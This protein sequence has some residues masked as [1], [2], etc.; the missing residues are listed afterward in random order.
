MFPDVSCG[1]YLF[2]RFWRSSDCGIPGANYPS[3]GS[4][5]N[6]TNRKGLGNLWHSLPRGLSPSAS[7]GSNFFRWLLWLPDGRF[8]ERKHSKRATGSD[9]DHTSTIRWVRIGAPNC[10][11]SGTGCRER[12]WRKPR[13][14]CRTVMPSNTD[15]LTI[16]KLPQLDLQTAQLALQDRYRERPGTFQCSRTI[17]AYG[18]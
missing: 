16:V 1:R 8:P 18:A 12:T 6:R 10:T 11:L 15:D 17:S 9:G 4:D 13:L 7:S 3:T 14:P 2:T 5:H